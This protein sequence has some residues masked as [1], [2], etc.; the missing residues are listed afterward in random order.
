[1]PNQRTNYTQIIHR[2]SQLTLNADK[3]VSALRYLAALSD[4]QRAEFESVADSNHVIVRALRA[5]QSALADKPPNGEAHLAV[6]I[7]DVIRRQEQRIANALSFLQGICRELEDAGCPVTVMKSLDHWPDLGN[8]LDLFSTAEASRVRDVMT[9]RLSANVEPRSWGDRLANKW[10]Y[11]IPDLPEVIEVHA[12]RLGQTGEHTDMARRFLTRRVPKTVGEF[13]FF[14]PAP[15][16]R[17][18]VATLQRMYRHFYFRVCD[19]VNTVALLDAGEVDFGELQRAAELGGI[20]N[21]VATY[22]K[23]VCDYTHKYRGSSPALPTE[24]LEAAR[25]GGEV[26]Y[27]GGRFIRVPMMPNAAELY[28][29]QFATLAAHGEVAAA[30]RL[31]LLPP[32][33]SAAAVAYRITGSDKGV[34]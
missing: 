21:G 24:V 25:F 23:I 11:A 17:I 32:L 13:M 27:V 12:Q 1:M 6:W 15:E 29:R 10:N 2:L 7:A 4:E 33:A 18:I 31:S 20:W 16:E 9:S 14:V 34:W 3:A 22:L 5:A 8:D 28:S 26:T 19:I 30:M